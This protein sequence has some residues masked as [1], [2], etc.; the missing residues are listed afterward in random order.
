MGTNT[1][2]AVYATHLVRGWEGTGDEITAV[3]SSGQVPAAL[4]GAGSVLE[5]GG[6]MTG[7]AAQGDGRRSG[8]GYSPEDDPR[9][10]AG[11]L[12]RVVDLQLRVPRLISARRPDVAYFPG[13]SMPLAA[14]REVPVVAAVQSMLPFHYPSQLGRTRRVYARLAAS[15]IARR[16]RRVIVPSSSVADDLMRHAGAR[17]EQ[18]VVIPQ[19]VD[20]DAFARPADAAADPSSFL[21]VSKPWDYKGL[22]TVLRALAVAR[23]SG[24]AAAEATLTVADGGITEGQRAQLSDY[25]QRVGVPPEAITFAGRVEH[26][27]LPALYHRAGTLVVPSAAES[28]GMM[29][30]EAAAAGCPVI[31]GR[32]HGMDETIGPVATQVPP[33][34]H[35]MLADALEEHAAMSAQEREEAASILVRWAGR[36]PWSRTVAETRQVLL[37]AA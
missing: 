29:F 8:A 3:F 12:D 18:L 22:V 21:F 31:A 1:G 32:G 36:F 7:R 30:L 28:F 4:A 11:S 16:A 6:R 5:I 2:G 15:H 35:R 20:L 9:T 13:N 27:A 10:R 23:S 33:H 37:E 26:D 24:G 34:S 19:G 25:A 17:R 14:P